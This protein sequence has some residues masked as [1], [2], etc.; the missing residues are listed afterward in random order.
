M[1]APPPTQR[2]RSYVM[3]LVVPDGDIWWD[4]AVKAGCRETLPFAVAPWGD[5]HGHMLDPFGVTWSVSCP[6]KR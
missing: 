6:A 2:S 4:R 5:K 3:Q 1:P